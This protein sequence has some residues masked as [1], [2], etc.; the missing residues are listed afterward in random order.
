VLNTCT[1]TSRFKENIVM[2]DETKLEF[3][4]ILIPFKNS[5]SITHTEEHFANYQFNVKNS[6]IH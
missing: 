3:G 6:N 4:S 1:K 2:K 5:Q